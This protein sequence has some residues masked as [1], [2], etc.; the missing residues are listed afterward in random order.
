[1]AELG[2]YQGSGFPQQSENRTRSQAAVEMADYSGGSDR[3]EMVIRAGRAWDAAVREFNSVAWRFNRVVADITLVADTKVYTLPTDFRSPERAQIIDANGA[4]VCAL[5]WV[6]YE[7]WLVMFSNQVTG[8]NQPQYYTALNVHNAGQVRYEPFPSGTLGYPKV[9]HTYLRRIALAPGDDDR[10][11]VPVE[12]DEAIFLLGVAKLV[13]QVGGDPEVTAR[14]VR[15]RILR[16]ACEREH[17]NFG[18]LT[19]WGANG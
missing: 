4:E 10:L 17:R 12:V 8:S 5:E 9:R 11:N 19:G 16:D 6:P 15:A 2:V 1:M 13:D 14:Y 18:E 7:R 3:P